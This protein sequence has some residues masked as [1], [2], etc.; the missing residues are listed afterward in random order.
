MSE[1]NRRMYGVMGITNS[2][3]MQIKIYDKEQDYIY[4]KLVYDGELVDKWHKRRLYSNHKGKQWFHSEMGRQWI[5]NFLLSEQSLE[6][7][8]DQELDRAFEEY[9]AIKVLYPHADVHV[10]YDTKS[11]YTRCEYEFRGVVESFDKNEV[12]LTDI[13][14]KVSFPVTKD[15]IINTVMALNDACENDD[16]KLAVETTVLGG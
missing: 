10:L 16:L 15:N 1:I 13:L 7:Y 14:C 6:A 4:Y 12:S 3:G 2:I 5:D 8:D 11:C 9:K